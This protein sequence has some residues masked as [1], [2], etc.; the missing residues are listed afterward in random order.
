MSCVLRITG[1]NLD[2]DKFMKNSHLKPYRVDRKGQSIIKSAPKSKKANSSAF[3][4]DVS[5]ADFSALDKQIKD[6]INFLKKNKKYLK[7]IKRNRTVDSAL[8][9]FAITSRMKS[10]GT[11]VQCDFFPAEL[12]KLA[13]ELNI[14]I[15]LS[16]YYNTR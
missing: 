15:E 16:Q 5:H 6:A 14:G 2:V 9:D 10:K 4:F 8:L 12:L 3:H 13:G 7:V 11:F 1:N